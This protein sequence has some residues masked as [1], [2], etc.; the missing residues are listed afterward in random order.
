MFGHTVRGPL[1]LL[2]EQL[3]NETKPQTNVLEYVSSF[4]ERLYR[5]REVAL[6]NLSS[7][8]TKMKTHFDKKEC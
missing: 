1:K 7:T 6:S 8:H 4:R 2:R 5:A 3:L